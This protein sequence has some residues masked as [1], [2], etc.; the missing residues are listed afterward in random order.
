MNAVPPLLMKANWFP[1]G[2]PFV[3]LPLINQLPSTLLVQPCCCADALLA[4]TSAHPTRRAIPR[5]KRVEVRL[6]E[7]IMTPVFW[8]N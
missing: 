6:S 2:T 1:A 5:S 8:L 3:Q 4:A 7:I